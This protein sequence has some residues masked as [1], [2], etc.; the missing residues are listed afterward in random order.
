LIADRNQTGAAAGDGTC[1][2]GSIYLD[3]TLI[4][5][6]E[7]QKPI[8]T[9]TDLWPATPATYPTKN[10]TTKCLKNDPLLV[11]FSTSANLNAYAHVSHTFTHEHLDNATY[12]DAYKEINWN[13]AW[14]DASGISKALKFSP[15][16]LVPPAITGLHN[17]DALKAFLDNGIVNVVGDNTRPLLLNQDNEH[18]PL[19]STVAANGYAG[20]QINPRWATNIYYNCPMP[21]CTVLEWAT[22][23]DGYGDYYTLLDVEKQTSTRHLLGLH[24]DSYMFHQANLNYVT[25]PKTTING[26]TAQISMVQA[27][28]ETVFQEMVRLTDWPMISLKHD[29]MATSFSNRMARD[30]CSPSL[31]YVTNPTKNTIT[32]MTIT[33][34][35]NTCSALIPVT[36]PGKVKSAMGFSTEQL[37]SD[38]LTSKYEL[39][40]PVNTANLVQ[41]GLK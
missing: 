27:W 30:L 10:Y 40:Y 31:T 41:F 13:Q 35:K 20:I 11:W 19:I 33:T 17:G 1:G 12:S 21:D 15:K 2:I 18:W 4:S 25:A 29:D 28:V 8:G 5:P 26:I 3:Q 16:G 7:F 24:H 6:V 23:S 38:P 9:G 32:G 22:T 14:L 34:I 36:V 37:G 39:V